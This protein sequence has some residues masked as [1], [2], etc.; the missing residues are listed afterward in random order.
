MAVL[1][2]VVAL[3][4]VAVDL[5]RNIGSF[6]VVGIEGDSAIVELYTLQ[7]TRGEQ[8]LGPY[9]RMRWHHPGPAFFYALAPVYAL[10]GK[11]SSS[12]FLGTRLLNAAFLAGLFVVILRTRMRRAS[13]W[14]PVAVGWIVFVFGVQ[15]LSSFWT[16]HV[17]IVPF[18]LSFVAFASFAS[19][20]RWALV[21]AAVGGSFAFQCQVVYGVPLLIIVAACA[22]LLALRNRGGSAGSS[23]FAGRPLAW[24]VVATALLLSIMWLPVCVEQL[25]GAPG[26]ISRLARFAGKE[27][28]SIGLLEALQV[29]GRY[30]SKYRAA[31]VVPHEARAGFG[32]LQVVS[33]CQVALLAFGLRVSRARGDSMGFNLCALGLFAVVAAVVSAMLVAGPLMPHYFQWVSIVGAINTWTVFYVF[34]GW[35]FAPSGRLGRFIHC[36]EMILCAALL[37]F[38]FWSNIQVA[39]LAPSQEEYAELFPPVSETGFVKDTFE[40]LERRGRRRPHLRILCHDAWPVATNLVL[41]WVKRGGEMTVDDRWVFMFGPQ[42]SRGAV[43]SDAELLVIRAESAR[44]FLSGPGTTLVAEHDDFAVLVRWDPGGP[45]QRVPKSRAAKGSM[46]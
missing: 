36:G 22:V 9:S 10:S 16:A 46:E 32:W 13:W 38:S 19:G 45:E 34:S 14:A 39:V 2:S 31:W 37:L 23:G 17:P 27:H 41:N 5:A 21:P 26:N 7:A 30:L 29:I 43:R 6:P 40:A 3:S 24:V 12:L 20:H 8:L 33:V 1:L 18:A 35:L 25:S 28:D 15:H 4:P 42:H 44:R 11:S